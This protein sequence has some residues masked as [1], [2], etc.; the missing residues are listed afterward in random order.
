VLENRE[1][2][3]NVSAERLYT[4]LIKLLMGRNVFDILSEYREVIAVFIPEI[5][6]IFDYSQHTKWHIYD[7]WLHTCKSVEQAPDDEV[8]RLIMLLHDIGKP[9][10]HQV[11]ENGVDHFKGHQAISW[12]LAS[13]VLKR[14]KVSNAVYERAEAVIPI[15]DAHIGTNR[16]NIKKWLARLGEQSF[17]DL[18]Q[19]KRADKLAQNTELIGEELERLDFT[20]ALAREIIE[21]GEA[22]TVRQ[23]AIHG[24]DLI[25]L[26]LEGRA[27]GELLDIMLDAVIS[28][29]LPN[30]KESLLDFAKK[31]LQKNE[32]ST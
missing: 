17:F 25:A 22:V 4:E 21:E 30:T 32:K 28:E 5:R 20:E 27:I 16:K 8:I 2:L 26:G 31:H 1:L 9:Y 13:P 19:V 6:A 7:A 12:E 11:D 15:H 29:E 14:L 10:S 24:N 23:L 3:K 18:T